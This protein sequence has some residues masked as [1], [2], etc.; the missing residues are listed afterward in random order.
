MKRKEILNIIVLRHP[1]IKIFVIFFALS[2]QNNLLKMKNANQWE[3]NYKDF[4]YRTD[5]PSEYSFTIISLLPDNKSTKNLPPLSLKIL[6][7]WGVL[8]SN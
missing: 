2:V 7:V 8:R 1:N 3:E 6:S 4:N 5:K